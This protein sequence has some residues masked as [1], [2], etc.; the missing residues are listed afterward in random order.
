MGT[1][2]DLRRAVGLDIRN[3]ILGVEILGVSVDQVRNSIVVTGPGFLGVK[4]GFAGVNGNLAADPLFVDPAH[5][6]FHLRAGSPAIDAGTSDG[7]PTTDLDGHPRSD[8]HPDIGAYE[9]V[10]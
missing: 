6:D 2:G 8:G 4:P 3:T 7:A 5:G 1:H 9:F 10:R